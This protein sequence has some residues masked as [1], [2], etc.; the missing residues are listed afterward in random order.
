MCF[1]KLQAGQSWETSIYSLVDFQSYI[2]EWQLMVGRLVDLISKIDQ[3][4]T[5]DIEEAG[6]VIYSLINHVF[7]VISLN[8]G[9]SLSYF[10]YLCFYE[11][12]MLI[13]I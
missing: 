9:T 6:I 5:K 3:L 1:K 12:V 2:F 8:G 7:A 11:N 10:A 13:I 4:F